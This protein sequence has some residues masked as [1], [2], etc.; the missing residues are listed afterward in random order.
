MPPSGPRSPRADPPRPLL[1]DPEQVAT[2]KARALELPSWDLDPRQQMELELLLGGAAAPLRGYL[3]REAHAAVLA[4]MRLPEGPFCPWPLTLDVDEATAAA[5]RPGGLL[6][7]RDLEGV[8]LAVLRV[9]EIWEADPEDEA[10]ALY[11]VRAAQAPRLLPWRVAG[12]VEGVELPGHHAFAALWHSPAELR[13]L[14]AKRGWDRVVA[15][16]LPG[17]V[18]A[19]QHRLGMELVRE[20]GA[21]LLLHP[22]V[23]EREDYYWLARALRAALP[24]FPE[25]STA[26]SLLGLPR[27]PATVREVLWQALLR[28]NLGCSHMAWESGVR[29]G[30]GP[31]AYGLEAD[32]VAEALAR[33]AEGLRIA[34]VPV[35][36]PAY[37]EEAGGFVPWREVPATARPRRLDEPELMARLREGREVP[38]WFS[39]PEVMAE[40]RQRFPPRSRQGFTLF[41]TGLSGAGKSTVAKAVMA[42]LLELGGRPVTLLDGDVVRKHLSSELGFSREHRN[43]NIRRIGFVASQITKNG[44]VAICAPIAPYAAVRQEVRE[45]I[46]PYG[47]FIEIHVATPL[48]V[49]E[50]RD[51][52]GLYAKA[53]AGLIREFT[54]I[55]DPYE[56]PEDPELRLDTSELS[57]EEAAQ[58]VFLYLEREGYIA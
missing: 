58:R 51:R 49:C 57:V 12:A 6:G 23:D 55:S 39:F 25:P 42:K 45:M 28:Q 32:E 3:G 30:A 37:L 27:R 10:R 47:G 8:L 14:F 46:S 1:A 41:F 31:D 15:L 21:N 48:E 34:L 26:L 40:L 24:R 2:L 13:A 35:P 43:L 18:H 36:A 52:K 20:L 53:R 22:V 4:G 50:R 44:G 9:E 5:L 19:A 38:A 16:H 11:G 29:E 33:A 56:P 17:P 54:G 7:L